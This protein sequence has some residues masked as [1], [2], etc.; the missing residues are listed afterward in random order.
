MNLI[1]TYVATYNLDIVFDTESWSEIFPGGYSV[2]RHAGSRRWLWWCFHHLPK[3]H[4]I[5]VV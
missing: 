4:L 5:H 2:Y 1:D 3:Y